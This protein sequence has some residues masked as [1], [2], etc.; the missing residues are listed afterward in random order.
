VSTL[1]VHHHWTLR[2]DDQRAC[3][4]EPAN[5]RHTSGMQCFKRAEVAAFM[6]AHGIGS[7]GKARALM[8][9]ESFAPSPRP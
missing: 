7:E 4:C 8:F 5:P 3:T 1:S 2:Q 6:L 9:L